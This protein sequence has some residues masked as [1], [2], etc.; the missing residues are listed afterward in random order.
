MNRVIPVL[1]VS[2]TAPEMVRRLGLIVAGIVAVVARRFLKDPT[3]HDVIVPLC[4]WLNRTWRRFGRVRVVPEAPGAHEVPKVVRA[5]VV[6]DA[7]V[8]VVRRRLPLRRAWLVRALGWEVAGYGSQLQALLAEP[9][10]VAL[11]T[12][13]PGVGR[14][15]RPLCRMLGVTA[16]EVARPAK[17][18]VAPDPEVVRA[19]KAR[20][21]AHRL[22]VRRVKGW[23]P[24]PIPS[25]WWP[26]KGV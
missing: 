4:G 19:R 9:E 5:P 13:A 16:L 20:V 25:A 6:R 18:V 1:R 7:Q 15:L 10:M 2:D 17:V 3:F 23:S 26:Q 14:L 12:A 8:R 22:W 21:R 11:L 24:G